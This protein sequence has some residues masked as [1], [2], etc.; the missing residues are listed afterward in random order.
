MS[1]KIEDYTLD[2]FFN[3]RLT[4]RQ[5]R[6]G[7]R[8]SIDAVLLAH[9]ATLKPGDMV[10]DMGMGCGIISLLLCYRH[11]GCRI[12]GI[13]LQNDLYDL[14]VRNIAANHLEKSITPLHQD[15]RLITQ[16]DTGGAVDL[17]LSNPPFHKQN[18]GRINPNSEQALARHEITVTLEDIAAA[19][20]RLLRTQG[21]MLIIYPADRIVDIFLYMRRQNIEPKSLT[22]IH[23][24]KSVSAKLAI[25]EGVKAGNPGLVV[26][27]P[28][29]IYRDVNVY[30][31]AVAEMFQV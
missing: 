29:I 15:I 23:S 5:K 11:P 26:R 14:A 10:V 3:G 20:G 17:I 12:I 19:A 8:F 25:I 27:A 24:N 30:S 6:F 18:S 9:R 1:K 28:L 2:K 13:E 7:Y 22:M 16:Q 4:I 31:E 21:K